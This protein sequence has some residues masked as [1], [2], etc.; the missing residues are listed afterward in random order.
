MM[1]YEY[2]ITLITR[3]SPQSLSFLLLFYSPMSEV[4][5]LAANI[6]EEI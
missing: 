6:W 3:A 2:G 5:R 4:W 1:I